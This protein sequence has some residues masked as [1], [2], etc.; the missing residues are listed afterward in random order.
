MT[1]HWVWLLANDVSQKLW[2]KTQGYK[3]PQKP[4]SSRSS[5]EAGA[6]V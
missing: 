6:L 5:T 3:K 4:S 2:L 1:I